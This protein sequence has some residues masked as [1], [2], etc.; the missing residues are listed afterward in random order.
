MRSGRIVGHWSDDAAG[1]DQR[2][3]SLQ[4]HERSSRYVD[5]H[6]DA[7]T[8]YT[9][10]TGTATRSVTVTGGQ[11]ASV[12]AITLNKTGGT[13]PPLTATVAMEN[14]AFNPQNVEVRAGGTVRWTNNDQVQHNATGSNFATANLG[15]GQSSAAI[16]FSTA[17]T[18]N[19]SCTL[20]AGMNGTVTVR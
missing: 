9:L 16:T 12:A 6:G 5:S 20:H 17:G 13:L 8:G 2:R 15:N 10:G 19:Y 3:G 1:D 7:T 4:F 18:F 11:Q 14:T